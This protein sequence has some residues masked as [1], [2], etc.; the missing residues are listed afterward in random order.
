[1]KNLY[2][3]SGIPNESVDIANP[4]SRHIL[5]L[6]FYYIQYYTMRFLRLRLCFLV[7]PPYQLD[8]SL[9]QLV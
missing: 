2:D 6:R 9:I 4:V 5:S 7:F 8:E 1:M 3:Y